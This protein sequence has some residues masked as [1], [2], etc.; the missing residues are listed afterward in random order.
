MAAPW[1]TTF[2]NKDYWSFAQHEYSP[3]RTAKEVSYLRD[4]VAGAPSNRV[5]DLGCGIG[6]HCLPLAAAG[7]DV[8]GID[9]SPW[10]IDE[11]R[12]RAGAEGTQLRL[13]VGDLMAGTDWPIKEVGAVVCIQAFGWGTDRDQLRLLR[14]VRRS[15]MPDG[16]L[17]LDFSNAMWIMRHLCPEAKESHGGK[18]FELQ[19][20][21]DAVTGRSRGTVTVSDGR[22]DPTVLTHDVRLYSVPEALAL[23]REAGFSVEALHAEFST[24]GA[25]TMDSRYVQVIARR[26]A[27]P[28]QGLALSAY[29]KGVP[30]GEV[31][32][33]WCP[34]ELDWVEPSPVAVWHSLW[35][36]EDNRLAARQRHYAVDDPLRWRTLGGDLG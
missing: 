6:R 24:D 33:R 11:A 2:F 32:L 8:I 34:D 35:D 20:H 17:V 19:R 29:S 14:R 5:A 23:V 10:A 31:D 13:V 7:L 3:E 16:L 12:R 21:Y 30:R 22:G 18:T 27:V 4:V 1:Y 15:L 9:V 28:P 25:V 26:Q 36:E